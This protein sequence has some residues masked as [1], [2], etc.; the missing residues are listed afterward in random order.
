MRKWGVGFLT[1]NKIRWKHFVLLLLCVCVHNWSVSQWKQYE[2]QIW[3]SWRN[4]IFRKWKAPRNST[5]EN[6][7]AHGE[8]FRCFHSCT[9]WIK[10]LPQSLICI[11]EILLYTVHIDYNINYH[12]VLI[13]ELE[14]PKCSVV[15]RYMCWNVSWPASEDS[16]VKNCLSLSSKL[17][18]SHC[19]TSL[20]QA[21]MLYFTAK[22]LGSF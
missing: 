9:W 10:T 4:T 11:E 17:Y 13:L 16:L 1:V 7:H 6:R 18:P 8:Y 5:P 21:P 3:S 15:E 19:G 12:W 14:A 2:L 22:W 20:Y